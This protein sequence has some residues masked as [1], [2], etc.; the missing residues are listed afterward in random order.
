MIEM[1]AEDKPNPM[2]ATRFWANAFLTVATGLLIIGGA[3]AI[4]PKGD[5]KF[6]PYIVYTTILYL[7]ELLTILLEARLLA[8]S[9]IGGHPQDKNLLL[10]DCTTSAAVMVVMFAM[11]FE[12]SDSMLNVAIPFG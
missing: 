1:Q 4:Y 3:L 7:A 11:T 12:L 2:H 10:V 6:M 5:D 8:D 9:S